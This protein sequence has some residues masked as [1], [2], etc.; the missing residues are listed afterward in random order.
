MCLSHAKA[1][2]AGEGL[3]TVRPSLALSVR[4]GMRADV[5]LTYFPLPFGEREQ[6]CLGEG[7]KTAHPHPCPPRRGG[8]AVDVL[9]YFM[10]LRLR[11]DITSD[12]MRIE[13]GSRGLFYV[14]KKTQTHYPAKLFEIL[15]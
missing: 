9:L 5:Q 11:A 4:E 1:T 2:D 7:L 3:K 10:F 14:Q 12:I 15:L 6:M 13:T 8:N